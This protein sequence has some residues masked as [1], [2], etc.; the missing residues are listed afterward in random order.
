MELVMK[1]MLLVITAVVVLVSGVSFGET[2]EKKPKKAVPVKREKSAPTATPAVPPAP[3]VPKEWTDVQT[4]SPNLVKI[5]YKFDGHYINIRFQNLSAERT[6]RIRYQAKWQKNVS[7]QWVED[8]SSEGL[9]LRLR[10]Q[11]DVVIDVLTRSA[12][13]KDVVIYIEASEML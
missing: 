11:E 2:K 12:D 13:I 3:A 7:G 10:K 6:V 9:T 4:D 1:N 5:A 8:A